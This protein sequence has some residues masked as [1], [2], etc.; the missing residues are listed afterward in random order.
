MIVHN[1]GMARG[2][3][4]EQKEDPSEERQPKLPKAS[5]ALFYQYTDPKGHWSKQ[6]LQ[7]LMTYLQT[8][9][10]H[11]NI[12]GRIRVAPEGVNAT[13][14]AVDDLT[15][16]RQFGGRTAQE[17]LRHV[18][19]DLKRFDPVFNL[20]DFKF[21]DDLSPDRHFKEL[22]ILPVQELVFYDI[23]SNEAPL[24]MDNNESHDQNVG[25]DDN[26]KPCRSSGRVVG[27][28]HH[29]DA[30]EYH[31]M[32]QKENTVVIDVRNHYEAILGRFDGQMMLK[33][34]KTS[35]SDEKKSGEST[36]LTDEDKSSNPADEAA[37]VGGGCGG[38]EYIDPKMRKSTDFKEWLAKEETKEKIK[39][40]TVMM[41]V[42]FGFIVLS[43]QTGTAAKYFHYLSII[44][45]LTSFSF[46][47]T[48]CW[49]HMFISVRAGSD[50]NVL[51]SISSR[52]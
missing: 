4:L 51:A 34:K 30:Q 36:G 39:G 18:A 33:K 1:S 12:G 44:E 19:A 7:L 47:L 48:Y 28:V 43:L 16:T 45:E 10:R 24:V 49:L 23:Q 26:N 5:L 37:S 3:T 31:M 2:V 9:A 40:K 11:R 21:I 46:Y 41:F 17:T 27:G 15:T 8:I 52:S 13:L 29:L 14:S 25:K 38:A 22:K 32:L 20:T 50:V 35:T 42:S 6:Q